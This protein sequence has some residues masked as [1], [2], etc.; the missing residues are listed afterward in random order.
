MALP[1][2]SNAETSLAGSL[3]SRNESRARC[4]FSRKPP[5]TP[6]PCHTVRP[7][8][9]DAGRR[10]I[11]APC[12]WWLWMLRSLNWL[13]S[14]D[15]TART[16]FF[17]DGGIVLAFILG[18]RLRT[19]TPE[20]NPARLCSGHSHPPRGLLSP[21]VRGLRGHAGTHGGFSQW[22]HGRVMNKGLSTLLPCSPSSR[23]M[24]LKTSGAFYFRP[25]TPPRR[26]CS[27][28]S[29][30]CQRPFHNDTSVSFSS[31]LVCAAPEG[32]APSAAYPATATRAS[33]PGA[34][35][36]QPPII[37]RRLIPHPAAAPH[38]HAAAGCL[39]RPFCIHTGLHCS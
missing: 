7:R 16:A 21:L 33:A 37:S 6:P 24:L 4:R 39:L 34:G 38:E 1:V 29:A 35:L 14:G 31:R 5:T 28:H 20:C 25:C 2:F 19:D 3:K 30:V 26:P 23:R 8:L 13:Y 12:P 17:G 27:P 22:K 36:R 18:A 11:C 9:E 10:C 32:D 15:G